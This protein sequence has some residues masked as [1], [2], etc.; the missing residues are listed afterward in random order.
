M[1]AWAASKFTPGQFTGTTG[2]NVL[3]ARELSCGYQAW[4][5]KVCLFNAFRCWF[6]VSLLFY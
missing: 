2:A 1:S 3:S 5:K 4:A 6:F